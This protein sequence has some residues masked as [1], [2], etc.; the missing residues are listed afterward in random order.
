[1]ASD[2]DVQLD[3]DDQAQL[4]RDVKAFDKEL[5]KALGQHI[6]AVGKPVGQRTLL[7]GS[8]S[9]PQSGGLGDRVSD[10][11]VSVSVKTG[12]TAGVS[13]RLLTRE[14]Y[15][16]TGIDKGVVRHKT[17]GRL[18]WVSQSIR[19]GVFTDQFK[20]EE[21]TFRTAVEKAVLDAART[22]RAGD[23]TR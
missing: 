15:D 1:M 23:V 7:R 20:R 5:S 3:P 2:F 4:L 16:L 22:I 8:G 14:G 6:R 12:R 11:R 19:A 9:L 18:P 21:H 10:G 13:I 17:F